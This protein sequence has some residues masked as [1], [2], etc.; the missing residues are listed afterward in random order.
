MSDSIFMVFRHQS[1]ETE[2]PLSDL[3][4]HKSCAAET[5]RKPGALTDQRTVHTHTHTYTQRSLPLLLFHLAMES[6][7]HY[8][9]IVGFKRDI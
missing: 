5:H 2:K 9:F 4:L 1:P 7:Q 6:Y 8:C 3:G